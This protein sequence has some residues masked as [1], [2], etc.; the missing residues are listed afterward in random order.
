MRAGRPGARSREPPAARPTSAGRRPGP[1]RPVFGPGGRRSARG[2]R[3]FVS[4]QSCPRRD[5]PRSRRGR[6]CSRG[7][8]P[9]DGSP[10]SRRARGRHARIT[11]RSCSSSP[12]RHEPATGS[13]SG[14]RGQ[15]LFN[16]YVTRASRVPHRYLTRPRH[17]S[18]GPPDSAGSLFRHGCPGGP[19]ACRPPAAEVTSARPRRRIRPATARP[20]APRPARMSKYDVPRT[21]MIPGRNRP[22]GADFQEPP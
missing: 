19:D 9:R 13:R 7:P 3:R 12:L 5:S 17:G 22:P 20:S 6:S 21:M 8:C 15:P 16:A 18:H 11:S 14:D 10:R 1:E 2:S 4:T